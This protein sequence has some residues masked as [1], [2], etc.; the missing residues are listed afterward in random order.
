MDLIVEKFK[1]KLIFLPLFFDMV[2]SLDVAFV[3]T[4]LSTILEHAM[5]QESVPKFS[6]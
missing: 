6:F 4:R 2:I 3:T 5:M 1:F